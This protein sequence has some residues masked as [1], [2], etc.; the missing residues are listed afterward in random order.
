MVHSTS[1]C[2]LLSIFFFLLFFYQRSIRLTK[3]SWCPCDSKRRDCGS[4]TRFV[5]VILPITTYRHNLAC[6]NV[7]W[8]TFVIHGRSCYIEERYMTQEDNPK[9]ASLGDTFSYPLVYG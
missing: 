6:S 5:A 3:I 1:D 9:G 4:R 7:E 2:T 8:E